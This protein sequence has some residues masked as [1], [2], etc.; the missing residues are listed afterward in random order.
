MKERI[1]EGVIERLP[2]YLGVLIQLRQE[3]NATVSSARLGELTDINPAQI[4]RDLTHFGS[5]GK[6]GVGYDVVS[7]I[8]RIQ[9]ILGSDH[10]HRLVLVGAG[11]LGSA[12][13]SYNGL[14]KHGFIVS[15]VFDNDADK[16]GKRIG[17]MIVQ[18]IEELPRYAADQATR[19]GVLAVPPESAQVAADMLCQAGVRVILNYSPTMVRVPPEVTLHN[20][21]PVR[22][23]LHTLYYLSR[24]DRVRPPRNGPGSNGGVARRGR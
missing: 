13:A 9:R 22:E 14:R 5:F 3:G 21:D 15:A 1:P 17:E 7:L 11:N 8:D 4:R 19:I 6:R 24:T 18:P 10:V 2:V 12:I 23:L 16:I 20:T